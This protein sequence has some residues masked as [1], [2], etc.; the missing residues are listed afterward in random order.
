[1]ADPRSCPR[2]RREYTPRWFQRAFEKCHECRRGLTPRRSTVT[3]HGPVHA[4]DLGL[5]GH[6]HHAIS[7]QAT[8]TGGVRRDPSKLPPGQLDAIRR[9]HL[10]TPAEHTED[11]LEANRQFVLDWLATPRQGALAAALDTD[12]TTDTEGAM[13]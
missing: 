6:R 13:P 1:M 10:P 4:Y 9:R 8:I 11:V 5:F 7:M 3:S 12:S 2:C